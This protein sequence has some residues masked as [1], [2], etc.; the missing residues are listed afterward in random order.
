MAECL[1]SITDDLHKTLTLPMPSVPCLITF[2]ITS[3]TVVGSL[4][5]GCNTGAVD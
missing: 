4:V 1:I 5:A 3:L 2:V